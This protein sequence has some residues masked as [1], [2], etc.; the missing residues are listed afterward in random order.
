MVA[1]LRDRVDAGEKQRRIGVYQACDHFLFVPTLELWDVHDAAGKCRFWA[2]KQ[3]SIREL[4]AGVEARLDRR[5]PQWLFGR[6]P[7]REYDWFFPWL[8]RGAL[9]PATVYVAPPAGIAWARKAW[10]YMAHCRVSQTTIY[11]Y[12]RW[13][14]RGL[15]P[16]LPWWKWL[17]G[18]PAPEGVFVVNEAMQ[19]LR[20]ERSRKAVW[21]AAKVSKRSLQLWDKDSRASEA[22]GA[23]LA[24]ASKGGHP[25]ALA[26]CP[27]WQE[28][29]AKTQE[30]M[31]RFA[32][33]ATVTACST[34]AGI[35]AETFTNQLHEASRLAAGELLRRHVAIEDRGKEHK[36][37]GLVAP[38]FFI[39]TPAMLRFRK[40]AIEAGRGMPRDLE[41][42]AGF[43]AWFGDWITPRPMNGKRH[44]PE[45][46][47][48]ELALQAV[49]PVPPV[50]PLPQTESPKAKRG[51]PP[52][53]DR[54][55]DVKKLCYEGYIRG[56]K[57]SVIRAQAE[58]LFGDA[59]PKNDSNVPTVV[60]RYAK[61]HGLPL[62]RP[63]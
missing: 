58:R 15:L 61:A 57:L 24:A 38:N 46:R 8:L 59:A 53:S 11:N 4:R 44:S 47:I 36:Q 27:A 51:R 54:A 43:D 26:C 19:K 10:D 29:S 1:V 23:A 37:A 60:A 31:W 6:I 49:P 35:G 7:L 52:R 5:I 17:Y 62:H 50:L 25:S 21:Q 48:G 39:P 63:R 2:G 18:G 32:K 42:R 40:A 56:Q 14:Q 9:P 22:L 16:G 41:K 45:A 34:R 3:W 12:G 20:Q 33:E 28:L 30:A 13:F 55:E